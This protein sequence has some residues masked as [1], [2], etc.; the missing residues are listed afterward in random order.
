MSK[1]RLQLLAEL[2]PFTN[3]YYVNRTETD[4]ATLA[5]VEAAEAI[6][7]G[8]RTEFDR[9]VDPA[10]LQIRSESKAFEFKNPMAAGV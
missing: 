8:T 6:L 5:G 3:L 9:R 10:Q 1:A 4:I 7:S 2:K